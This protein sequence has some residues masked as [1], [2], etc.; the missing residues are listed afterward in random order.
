M[1][2]QQIRGALP[3]LSRR[4]HCVIHS[5]YAFWRVFTPTDAVCGGKNPRAPPTIAPP[6]ASARLTMPQH[7]GAFCIDPE[8][9]RPIFMISKPQRGLL[10]AAVRVR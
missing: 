5:C 2:S 9:R 3:A 8:Q 10:S 1:Q 4:C 7:A 6:A